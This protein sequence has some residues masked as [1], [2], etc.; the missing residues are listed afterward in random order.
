M[1]YN[2]QIVEYFP[3]TGHDFYDMQNPYPGTNKKLSD[4][5]L[6]IIETNIDKWI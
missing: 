3:S 1:D 5:S 4:N 6:V 2:K